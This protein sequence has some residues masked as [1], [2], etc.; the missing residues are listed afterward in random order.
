MVW[1]MTNL[2]NRIEA[3]E[4]AMTTRACHGPPFVVVD[5]TTDIETEKAKLAGV[6]L[7]RTV[8]VNVPWTMH[9]LTS[10]TPSRS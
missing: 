1:A 2:R 8:F 5:S 3:L 10:S 9:P 6:D 4:A 7:S